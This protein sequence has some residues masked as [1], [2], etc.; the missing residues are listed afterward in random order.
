MALGRGRRKL[1]QMLKHVGLMVTLAGLIV[2]AMFLPFLPGRLRPQTG[3]ASGRAR[4]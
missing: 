1:G 3:R 4:V 2:L